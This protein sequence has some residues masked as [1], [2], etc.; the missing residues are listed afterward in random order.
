[1]A[2]TLQ[3]P[4]VTGWTISCPPHFKKNLLHD[5]AGDTRLYMCE[6]LVW[7]YVMFQSVFEVKV[8]YVFKY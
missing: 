3:W 1:M 8:L 5:F 4:W 2:A 7:L 6:L